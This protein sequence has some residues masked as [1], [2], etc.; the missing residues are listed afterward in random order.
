M[1]LEKVFDKQ[2]LAK[3]VLE[4]DVEKRKN[5]DIPSLEKAVQKEKEKTKAHEQMISKFVKD[6]HSAYKSKNEDFYIE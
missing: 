2:R 6:V 4:A 5:D 3:D 1:V